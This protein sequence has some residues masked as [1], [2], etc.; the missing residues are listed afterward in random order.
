MISHYL[1]IHENMI[2]NNEHF[3]PYSRKPNNFSPGISL[4][5]QTWFALA[6]FCKLVLP[7]KNAEY[8]DEK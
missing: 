5:S 6:L 2:Q 7:A 4:P 8:C 1:V 3:G